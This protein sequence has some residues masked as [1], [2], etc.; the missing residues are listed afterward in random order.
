[1]T[2]IQKFTCREAA[3]LSGFENH[4]MVDYLC[5]QKILVPSLR[6]APGRGRPRLFS[7]WDVVLLRAIN[8]ILSAGVPVARLK[9]SMLDAQKE[10]RGLTPEEAIVRR[11]M[12]T[13]GKEVFMVEDPK[14]I[15]Q[16][17]KNGQLAFAFVLDTEDARQEVL[18]NS[19]KGIAAAS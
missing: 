1:M 9:Q 19:Q 5:R 7:F 16:L 15:V 3:R 2:E 17:T 4:M 8:R 6:S 10:L 13:D 14:L 18:E 11:F 12:V